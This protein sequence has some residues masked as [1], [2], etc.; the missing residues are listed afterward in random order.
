[1]K[2]TMT[3][4]ETPVLPAE[5]TDG[6]AVVELIV[7]DAEP[8]ASV[9]AAAA[10]SVPRVALKLTV[11]PAFATPDDFHMIV[12]VS[13]VPIR[14]LA[15]AAGE[16]NVN[17]SLLTA[18]AWLTFRP[19][20]AAVSVSVPLLTAFTVKLPWPEVLVVKVLGFSVLSF[21]DVTSTD[22]P[23]IP[24]PAESTRETV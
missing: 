3:C 24:P 14:M 11:W 21:V 13:G 1:M 19:A 9:V 10:L 4:A 16:V 5:I 6:P 20:A 22:W 12:T 18:T 2:L 17:E 15:L 8:S 23:E 7:T